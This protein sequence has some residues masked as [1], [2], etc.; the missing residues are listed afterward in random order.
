MMEEQ[1]IAIIEKNL[2][3]KDYLDVYYLANEHWRYGF[4]GFMLL[5][6]VGDIA[7]KSVSQIIISLAFL[8]FYEL[9]LRVT[10]KKNFQSSKILKKEKEVKF[11]VNGIETKSLDGSIHVMTNWDEFSKVKENKKIIYLMTGS[12]NGHFFLK[13][14]FTPEQLIQFKSLIKNT[15]DSKLFKKE[16]PLKYLGLGVLLRIGLTFVSIGLDRLF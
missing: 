2:E 14:N 3:F 12:T 13:K 1:Q 10:N 15:L 16:N 6:I 5:S 11:S 7:I 4:Y 8:G 9:L